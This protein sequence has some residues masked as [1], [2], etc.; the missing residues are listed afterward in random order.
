MFSATQALI[1]A[2]AGATYLSIFVGRVD[3]M[4]TD[5]MDAI[6]DA[7]AMVDTYEFESEVLVAVGAAPAPPH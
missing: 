2:K 5:G 6:R 1:A 3:D 4:A 7:V